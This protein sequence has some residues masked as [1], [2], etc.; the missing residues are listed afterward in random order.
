M[1]KALA[2]NDQDAESWMVPEPVVAQPWQTVSQV[3]VAL[4]SGGYS[5]L[6]LWWNDNWYFVRD[7]FVACYVRRLPKSKDERD[8]LL[9][10]RLSVARSKY[11]LTLCCVPRCSIANPDTCVESLFKNG[12]LWSEL[13]V[14]VVDSKCRSPPS[15]H[16]DRS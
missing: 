13:P 8:K 3:R 14:L 7:V 10:C 16:P 9:H 2:T 15:R 1:T 5:A 4:L 6:P 12:A 11:G